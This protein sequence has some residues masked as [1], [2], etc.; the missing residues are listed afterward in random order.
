MS[1]EERV[2]SILVVS[3]SEKFNHEISQMLKASLYS[4][5]SFADSVSA[6]RRLYSQKQYDFI[7]INSPLPDEEGSSLAIDCSESAFSLV[8]QLIKS[9]FYDDVCDKVSPYGV[10]TLP[11]PITKQSMLNALSWMRTAKIRLSK[12]EKKAASVEDKMREIRLVNKAKWLLISKENMDE[13]VAHRT[14]EKAAMDRC[15][16]KRLIAEEIIRKYS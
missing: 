2:Y 14:I 1:L 11:K 8:L 9:D 13:A 12:V 3:S 10:F 15:V 16:A 7:I 6:A 4:P 5:V